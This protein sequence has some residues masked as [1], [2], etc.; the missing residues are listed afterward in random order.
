MSLQMMLI[1]VTKVMQMVTL[2]M[3]WMMKT[4][5]PAGNYL[6]PN[7][8]YQMMTGRWSHLKMTL[9]SPL[10]TRKKKFLV[11]GSCLFELLKRCPECGDVIIK[12]KNKTSGTMLLVKLTC[13]SGHTKTWESQPVVKRKPLGNLL[14][15]AAILF[16]GNTFS[17][18]SNLAS[19]LNL[20]FFCERVFCERVFYGTQ[21]KYLF[22][23]VNEAWEAESNRQIDILTSKPVVN[24]EGDGRC[25]SPG[26][27]AKY[28][29]YTL[30]D[31]DTG[32]VVAFN[33]VQVSEVSSSNAIEKE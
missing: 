9:K 12:R 33:V 25:D 14:L 16:T 18:V 29:T 20:Q 32:N 10:L 1:L 27:C 8:S 11:F 28:G 23:V 2:I 19:C 6:M 5:T 26:H 21:R 31:E 24:L 4:W 3:T 30:M 17:S 22:P 15:A 7:S 13:H